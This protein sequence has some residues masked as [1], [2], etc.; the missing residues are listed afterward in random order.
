MIHLTRSGTI[1]YVLR[2]HWSLNHTSLDQALHPLTPL[3]CLA[4]SDSDE[5][6]GHSGMILR[7]CT[8]FNPAHPL[9]AASVLRCVRYSNRAAAPHLERDE[10]RL[11]V[12]LVGGRRGLLDHSDRP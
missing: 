12:L 10:L 5:F 11:I 7:V 4:S 3:L 2:V 6:R 9:G 1:G 8:Y